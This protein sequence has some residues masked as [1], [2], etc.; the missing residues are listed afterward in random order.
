MRKAALGVRAH[1]GWAT[2][3]VLGEPARSPKLLVT[4]RVELVDPADPA[5]KQPYHAAQALDLKEAGAL[6]KRIAKSARSSAFEVL[7]R[8]F[9]ELGGMGFEAS[10]CGLILGS[11]PFTKPLEAILASHPLVHTA[12]GV[13]FREAVAQAVERAGV[14]LVGVPERELFAEATRGLRLTTAELDRRLLAFKKEAGSP[15]RQE[16]K[17]AALVAWLAL[18]RH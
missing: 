14:R 1:S 3:V 13:L 8:T 17:T 10:A 9:E 11:A 5:A 16:Q 2:L 7:Q 4:R 18:E 12:E 15:W 6:V